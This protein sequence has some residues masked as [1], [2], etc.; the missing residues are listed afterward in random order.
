MCFFYVVVVVLCV[1]EKHVHYISSAFFI[2]LSFCGDY[3]VH[4]FTLLYAYVVG[5]MNEIV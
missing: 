2:S 3:R 1:K 5:S 4:T